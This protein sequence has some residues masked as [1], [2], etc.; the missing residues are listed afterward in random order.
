MEDPVHRFMFILIALFLVSNSIHAKDSRQTCR[1]EARRLLYR[2]I[3][4]LIVPKQRKSTSFLIYLPPKGPRGRRVTVPIEI[5][6]LS[7]MIHAFE[8]KK[9]LPENIEEINGVISLPEI[10]D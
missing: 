5:I 8:N 9:T 1:I 3:S 10:S 4:R 7:A 6:D 2:T